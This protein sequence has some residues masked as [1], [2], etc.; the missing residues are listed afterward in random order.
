M[1]ILGLTHDENGT[2]VER[3]PVLIKVA[4]GEGPDPGDKHSHPKRL[5]HFTLKRKG[6][7]GKDIVW[8][9]AQDLIDLHSDKPTEI[10][11][12]FMNDDPETVLK[13]EYAW[14]SA[15]ECKCSGKLVQVGENGSVLRFEM[16]AKRRTERHPEGELWPGTF[17]YKTG[18]KAGRPVE[19]CGD[20]CPDLERGDCKPSADL[21]FNLV[22]FP[23]V[24]GICQ[25][26][27]SSYR[28]IRNLSSALLQI[29]R[30]T[31]GRLAGIKAM[32][33][34]APEKVSFDTDNGKKSSTAWI[35]SL[36]VDAASMEKL[37]AGM[38]ETAK[39][40]ESTR[41]ALGTARVVIDEDDEP[42]RAREIGPEFYDAPSQ[43]S[44]AD[45]PESGDGPERSAIPPMDTD[46]LEPRV[47]ELCAQMGM[48][49]A[50]TQMLLG[51]WA[52]RFA[53][54]VADLESK[55]DKEANQ[56]S[57]ATGAGNGGNGKTNNVS[58]ARKTADPPAKEPL[59]GGQPSPARG[60]AAEFEW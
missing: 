49:A 42:A 41:K 7:A 53:E 6:M 50:K 34:M 25:I 27:T 47:L 44:L 17:K 30:I 40:F 19:P 46:P 4:I 21:Y 23:I 16:R 8:T 48:N 28:S 14:W 15:T 59:G 31:G 32:L 58:G 2:P 35:L 13:T 43:E 9:G 56:E 55:I 37:L 38:T 24:G 12:I 60:Q 52:G 22:K 39:L 33:C 29:R 51:Q 57:A 54:L 45:A 26:H 1:G 20:G 5:D 3:L 10:P 11:V 18:D 36:K